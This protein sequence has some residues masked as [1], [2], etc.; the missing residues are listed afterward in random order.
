[1]R[2]ERLAARD[3]RR[4]GRAASA[5]PAWRTARS[6]TPC[7]CSTTARIAAIR[8][9]VELPNYGVFDEK[10]VF[11]PGPLPGPIDHPRRPDRRADL[12]GHLAPATS[13]ECLAETGARDPARART[14]RPTGATRRDERLQLAVAR[15]A[16][17]GAADASTSTRSAGRTSSSSTA[18]RSS[19]SRANARCPE[20]PFGGRSRHR[21][22]ARRRGLALRRRPDVAAGLGRREA[23]L[24][25]LRPRPARL[26]GEERL[27]GRRAR[28][29]GRHRLALV[30]GDG[31]RRARRRARPLPHAALP[32][33]RRRRA[34][35][36]PT[37]APSALGVRYDVVPIG[38]P[39]D[40]FERA[41][42]PLFARRAARRHRGEHPVAHARHHPDGGLQQARLDAR[43]DRQQVGDVGRLR[44]DLRRHERRLQS[45]QGPLQD[46][47]ST[48]SAACATAGTP[49]GRLGPDGDGDP[50]QHPRTRRRAPSCART[51]RTRIRC[52]PTRSSTTSSPAW[53]RRS[54]GSPRS[55]R[56]ATIRDRQA[57]SSGCSTSPS[58]SGGSRRPA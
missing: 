30:R 12:R 51:R 21:L 18:P 41:L 14:A 25:G 26:C 43:H 6:T 42:A 9:K 23:D 56:A 10:R 32:L 33:H 34:S 38:A 19:S 53:S 49:D 54:C 58:T 52:R 22:G 37:T 13:C 17:S 11:E 29:L 20:P 35:P 36:T 27:P 50:G 40:G 2:R 1:M 31:R 3:R 16:E 28:P 44:D 55:S 48:G 15:V 7:C 46:A 47:R 45:D 24:A 8:F 57:R 5:C 4:A 39:V